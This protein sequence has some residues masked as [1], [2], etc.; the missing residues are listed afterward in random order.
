[1]A[2]FF[3]SNSADSLAALNPAVTVEAEYGERCVEGSQITMAH[4]GPRSNNPPPC[5]GGTLDLYLDSDVESIVGLSHVDLDTLGGIMRFYAPSMYK[6]APD[7]FWDVA[8]H[9]DLNGAH[10]LFDV[11]P[12]RKV[13]DSLYAFWAYSSKNRVQVPRDGSAIDIT[14]SINEYIKIIADIFDGNEELMLEG[15]RFHSDSMQLAMDSFEVKTARYLVRKSSQ[16]VNHLYRDLDYIYPAVI[17]YNTNTK[18]I[19]LSFESPIEGVSAAEIMQSAFGPDAGGH[20]G[21]A[22]SPRGVRYGFDD[23]WTVTERLRGIDMKR[24]KV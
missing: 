4:H 6:S 24:F 13:V 12:S 14:E 18:A 5:V 16:F 1:M 9:V 11:N 7:G 8:G 3:V 19:T 10:R 20:A 15:V 23:V 2:K 22:G 17:G 21:I